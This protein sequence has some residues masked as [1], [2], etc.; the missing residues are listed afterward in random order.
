VVKLQVRDWR[1]AKLIP[2][3]ELKTYYDLIPAG[4]ERV[5]FAAADPE[6]IVLIA[7]IINP[8]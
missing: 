8:K 6:D 1:T 4:V 5:C 7:Q 2:L 3:A